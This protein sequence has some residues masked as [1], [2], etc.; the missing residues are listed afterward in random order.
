MANLTHS[1]EKLLRS[2][3]TPPSFAL[4][5]MLAVLN[6]TTPRYID[7]EKSIHLF[8]PNPACKLRSCFL[9]KCT[10]L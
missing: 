6:I 8:Y 5:V 7:I 4:I 2:S 3:N 10:I 1:G 9:I